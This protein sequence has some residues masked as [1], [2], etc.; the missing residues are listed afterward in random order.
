MDA[1][2]RPGSRLGGRDPSLGRTAISE[3]RGRVR[4]PWVRSHLTVLGVPPARE[5]QVERLAKVPFGPGA[6]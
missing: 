4:G 2:T 6:R 3:E 5:R 1:A